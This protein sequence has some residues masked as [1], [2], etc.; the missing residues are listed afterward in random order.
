MVR[1]RFV[2][3][4]DGGVVP[5]NDALWFAFADDKLV[6][7]AAGE[8]LRLPSTATLEASGLPPATPALLGYL[9]G[10]PCFAGYLAPAE[11][12][13]GMQLV[14]LRHAFGILPELEYAI[15]GYASQI[16]HWDR[17]SR[18]CPVCGTRTER[19]PSEWAKQCP[20]CGFLQYPRISPA[21][22]VLIHRPGQILLT[23]QP[24]WPSNRYSLVAGF[25]EPGE[26][27]E[28]CLRREVAEEV[29]VT[30]DDIRYLG[31][32]PWPFPHQLMVGFLARYRAG[33]L[34]IDAQ[35]L[36]HAAW[37][38]LGALPD[39][40]PPLSISRRILDWYLAVQHDPLLP[41]PPFDTLAD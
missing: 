28:E 37:F 13:D 6:L 32:Q 34:R 7:A 3:S 27:L 12:P 26:S 4:A 31:S 29:G 14:D 39:L 30:V 11:I 22:I 2:R 25:V 16:V 19:L 35:E 9:D 15:A 23:R 20:A 24:T 40:P 1:P 18:F 5:G 10:V 38:D 17:T 36:E 21:I 8:G 41:F 33:E